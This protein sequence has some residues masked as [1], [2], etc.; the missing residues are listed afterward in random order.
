VRKVFISYARQNKRDIEQLVEHLRVLGCDTW[1]DSSLHG[2]QDWWEEILQRI[3]DCDTFIAIISRDALSSTACRREFDWAES[4]DKPV[5]PV[6]VEPPPK[7]LPRR[8]SKRQIV[9]Y[10]DRES[11]DRAALTLAG[12]LA[13]LPGAPPL[14]D[15]LPEQPAAPLSYLTDLVDLVSQPEPLDHGQQRDILNQLEPALRSIDPEERRGGS[16]ILEMLSSRD[17][18]YADVDRTI[19]R[20]RDLADAPATS[21]SDDEHTAQTPATAFGP[22]PSASTHDTVFGAEV[23]SPEKTRQQR[24]AR[25]EHR[26]VDERPAAHPSRGEAADVAES[27]NAVLPPADA[28]TSTEPTADHPAEADATS[29]VS[30]APT[31]PVQDLLDQSIAGPATPPQ[32]G[33]GA[34]ADLMAT[35]VV[36]GEKKATK[37]PTFA[38]KRP[39]AEAKS[40]PHPAPK[41]SEDSAA[42]IPATLPSADT[43]SP[44]G[45]SDVPKTGSPTSTEDRGTSSLPPSDTGRTAE[46]VPSF[47]RMSRR[48]KIMVATVAVGVI[49]V[50]AV[51]I[52]VGSQSSSSR[53]GSTGIKTVNATY[54]LSANNGATAT[55]TIGD[56]TCLS[57]DGC[58][59]TLASSRGWTEH[60]FSEKGD[61][62]SDW[63]EAFSLPLIPE[64]ASCVQDGHQGQFYWEDATLAGKFLTPGGAW[65]VEFTLTKTG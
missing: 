14:P 33:P 13:T 42:V 30:Q 8:F 45:G 34:D 31:I 52:I 2:G 59:A 25:P 32:S 21:R 53:S 57:A 23:A 22:E 1:H 46:G 44:A 4:L 56:A 49:A 38:Q 6:A 5:M 40:A 61:W 3:A 64:A 36:P 10:S 18:L 12:G 48:T 16:D 41:A 35:P 37:P 9:D 51:V 58:K 62:K 24:E 29:G 65:C 11:R 19:S 60:I 28:E 7:A 55:W 26:D 20:L 15:P 50:V 39:E 63:G 54:A 27:T 47:Q 17:D 43:P